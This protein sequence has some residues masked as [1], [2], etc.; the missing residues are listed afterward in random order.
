MA[1]RWR[2]GILCALAL[3]ALSALPVRGQTAAGSQAHQEVFLPMLAG[4]EVA[5]TP[6][7]TTPRTEPIYALAGELRTA[8]GRRY[9][10]YLTT[11]DNREFGLSGDSPEEETLIDALAR[12]GASVPVKVWG[13]AYAAAAGGEAS[14]VVT[15]ILPAEPPPTPTPQPGG[16]PVAV[17]RF[18]LVTLRSGPSQSTAAAGSVVY[19]QRC[20]IVGRYTAGTWL[21]IDCGD[22]TRGWI[23]SR[24]AAVEG[25]LSSV[26]LFAQMPTP[27]PASTPT[28][29]PSPTPTPQAKWRVTLFNN[30]RLLD[31]PV[32]QAF[33]DTID[34]DWGAGSPNPLLPADGFS[35]RF[36]ATQNFA[37]GVY[38]FRARADDGVRVWLDD[39]LVI[40]EWR[41]P[42]GRTYTAT[43]NLSGRHDLRVEY[44]EA[45]GLAS[46]WFE[47]AGYNQAPAWQAEYFSNT[48]L[49]GSP[50]TV[51]QE[52]PSA[53]PLAYD[54]GYGSPASGVPA[55]LWSA[56]WSGNFVFDTGDYIFRAIADDGVRVSIDGLR[57]ID[58]WRD[59]YN[60]VTN[61]FIGVGQGLHSVVVEYYERTGRAEL[62]V[63][64]FP[65]PPEVGPR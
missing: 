62:Q 33:V 10:Y 28:P 38:Q 48:A 26:P 58:Q 13:T 32:A 6:A 20:A 15:G 14:I 39:Q 41:G 18:N 42:S 56:R 40:D 47:I 1:G 21:E 29:L 35:M 50:V 65:A 55:D 54:W 52:P 64:W 24:L 63:W 27:R 49:A 34:F 36:D 2:I 59:G 7:P 17:V 46:L 22:G 37:P 51:Q 23:D 53:I 45:S 16:P 25:D 11:A 43:R 19:N 4:Y 31:P 5:A 60:N 8:V 3:A 57:V 44:Y 12:P 9:S 30:M 61:R